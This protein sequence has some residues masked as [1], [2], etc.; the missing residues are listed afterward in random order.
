VSRDVRS[1]EGGAAAG[2]GVATGGR[3]VAGGRSV[4]ASRG[5]ATAARGAWRSPVVRLLAGLAVSAAF[6]TVTVSRVDLGETARALAGA[7]PGGVLLAIVLVLVELTIRAER[8][9]ILLHP[10]AQVPLRSAFAYL[11]VGY[12]ANTLLPARLGDAARAY[13]A[14][15]S[16]GISTLVT[17]GTVV[18]ERVTDT[19]VILLVVLLAGLAVAPGSQIAGSAAVLTAVVLIGLAVAVA[20]GVVVLRSGLLDRRYGRQARAVVARVA[21]G[22]AAVRRPRGAALILG[23]TVLPFGVGVCTFGAISGALGLPLGPVEWAL[24]L[25][26]LALSTAIPAAPGS[27]GTYEFAGVTALGILGIGPS[28]ALAATVLIHVIAALPPAL[29]GLVST[30]ILHVRIADLQTAGS[31]LAPVSA[32]G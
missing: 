20:V 8:W 27:L 6:L 15:R 3:G 21:E 28:Q 7:A 11:T 23:L 18:V 10:S 5:L 14:A 16:F 19:A 1:P 2:R 30:L 22:A 12:F 17:L 24:V 29:L 13:L 31:E 4:V 9:R 25:G 32:E 26:V